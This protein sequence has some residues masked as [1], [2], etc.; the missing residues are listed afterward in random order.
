MGLCVDRKSRA[1]LGQRSQSPVFLH[2]SRYLFDEFT[3][4]MK[5]FAGA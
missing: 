5:E 2:D 1:R 4:L 3:A